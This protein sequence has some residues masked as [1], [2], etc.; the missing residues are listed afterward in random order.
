M[1]APVLKRRIKRRFEE[2]A[3]RL[4]R[5]LRAGGGLSD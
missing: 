2:I 4:K 5:Y 1:L 3:E